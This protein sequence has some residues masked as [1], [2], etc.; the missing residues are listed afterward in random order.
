MKH[1]G[2]YLLWGLIIQDVLSA[3]IKD[4]FSASLS[5]KFPQDIEGFGCDMNLIIAKSIVVSNE[6]SLRVALS[7]Q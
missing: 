1:L 3:G 4:L 6:E 7:S 2:Y 5:E